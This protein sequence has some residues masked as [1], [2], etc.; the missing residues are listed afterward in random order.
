MLLLLLP[1]LLS[2]LVFS[3]T[4]S[5]PCLSTS[6]PF[7]DIR[8]SSSMDS[9]NYQKFTHWCH[10]RKEQ[11]APLSILPRMSFL[12]FSPSEGVGSASSL[13]PLGIAQKNWAMPELLV[14]SKSSGSVGVLLYERL[15]SHG[16]E[17]DPLCTDLQEV[18]VCLIPGSVHLLCWGK[19]SLVS[20]G[21]IFFVV[22]L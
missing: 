15:E 8:K 2:L 5:S 13:L 7:L 9:V 11:D 4:F 19:G 22:G 21:Y 17:G 6:V 3:G 1:L 16:N 20:P 18:M 12:Q 14:L 10:A